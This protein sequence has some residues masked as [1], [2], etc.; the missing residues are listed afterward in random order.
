MAGPLVAG[1]GLLSRE[2]G[3]RML[4]KKLM[5]GAAKGTAA[6]GLGVGAAGVGEMLTNKPKKREE[7]RMG[8]DKNIDKERIGK[9]GFEA[10]PTKKALKK[11]AKRT[12]GYIPPTEAELNALSGRPGPTM[13]L[14]SGTLN[15]SEF[16]PAIMGPAR[17][18]EV[19]MDNVPAPI[20]DRSTP[21]PRVRRGLFG[22]DIPEDVYQEMERKNREAGFYGRFKKGGQVKKTKK[23]A[24]GGSVS[25]ASK[26]GD[27]CAQRGKT[28]GRMV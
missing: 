1:V 18:E 13:Q 2:L 16:G 20:E 4:R 14:E 8:S 28:K 10:A 9:G 19:T 15:P 22:E 5:E 26:R 23:Y 6:A 21:A 27:G 17:A 12:Y 11:P 24:S 3:K 7:S 25:S